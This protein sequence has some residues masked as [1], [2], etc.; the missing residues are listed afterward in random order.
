[1]AGDKI[2]KLLAGLVCLVLAACNAP[3]DEVSA[4]P[5]PLG[6]FRLGHNI[7]IAD[8]ASTGPFARDLSETR[9]EASVQ[10][11][12]A[13][14][15]RR[16]DG[17]GLY[18]LGV[19]IGRLVLANPSGPAQFAIRPEMIFDVT[20]FD[21]ATGQALNAKPKRVVAGEGFRTT[22]PIIGSRF[23][24]PV[25][26]QLQNLSAD[27]ARQIEAWLLENPD[28]FRP[29]ADQPRVPFDARVLAPDIDTSSISDID[30]A[31]PAN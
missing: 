31:A 20:V 27:A 16:Y 24:P 5:D 12:V 7:A 28:W 10:N 29:R 14:R 18:H 26:A 8:H 11:A 22:L 17:D 25:E 6:Q 1:M 19:V 30:P 21:D 4:T 13:N 2:S 3:V 15:L 23:V 9:I